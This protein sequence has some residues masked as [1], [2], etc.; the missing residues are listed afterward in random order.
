MR[1]IHQAWNAKRGTQL[2]FI[3]L[4]T[5]KKARAKEEARIRDL[6]AHADD[7]DEAAQQALD[8]MSP[9]EF[10]ALDS[11]FSVYDDLR[12]KLIDRGVPSGEIAFIHDA[13]TDLQKEELF[14]KVRA[15]QVRFLF[16]STPKM[17][18]GTN[19]QN[20][21]VALHHLDAPWRPSDLEQ[22]DGRGIRQ[23]NE[24]YAEDPDGFELEILRYATKNTLDARQWQTIEGKARFIQ[25][26]R[27][28]GT[29]QREIEDIAGEAANAA[30]MKAAA[31]G[32]PL[33]LEEMDLRQ[34]VRRLSSQGT[35]HDRE[36]HRIR[37]RIRS[38]GE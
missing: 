8:K 1:R 15:G 6:M 18:A 12:Q 32:N 28:G 4:S 34:K 27:K 33:I 25:Q 2:V 5:P 21:L 37:G 31:S 23:G 11:P 19:V 36:Q 3:D 35:E 14:G 29:K 16:G 7:G 10:L 24:L 38:L 13:N 9:D 20:R 22:R 30:E 17:G 26:V